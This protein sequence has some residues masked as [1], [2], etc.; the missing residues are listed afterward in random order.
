MA[1]TR[2]A[3]HQLS[4][5]S[6]GAF[7]AHCIPIIAEDIRE[8]L[9]C[10]VASEFCCS[11]RNMAMFQ[12]QPL[13]PV[14]A[15]TRLLILHGGSPGSEIHCSVHPVS[16]ESI[17]SYE[18]LSYVW[19][20]ASAS[21]VVI[22]AGAS[23]QVT[24]SLHAALCCLR[25]PDRDCTLWVDAL[26]INQDDDNERTQ[27]VSKMRR[28]YE[29]AS[30]VISWLG[31][32][33]EGSD[34]AMRL[35]RYIGE[36]TRRQGGTLLGSS[37][38]PSRFTSVSDVFEHYGLQVRAQNW[39]ALWD[40]LERPYWSRIWIVQELSVR[41][42]L[43]RSTGVLLCGGA[44][45]ERAMYDFACAWLESVLPVVAQRLVETG[46][47]ADFGEPYSTLTDR[48]IPAG[49]TMSQ[50]IAACNAKPG[51]DLESLIAAT[52]RFEASDPRDKIFALAGI[53]AKVDLGLEVNYTKSLRDVL[54][55]FVKY[56]LEKRG[57]L[58]VLVGNRQRI[59]PTDLAPSW[60]PDVLV[61]TTTASNPFQAPDGEQ[62]AFRAS[63][64]RPPVAVFQQGTDQLQVEGIKLGVLKKVIG[65]LV[66]GGEMSVPKTP[67]ITISQA[68]GG[69]ELVEKLKEYRPPPDVDHEAFWRTL[70][71]DRYMKEWEF[72]HPAPVEFGAMCRVLLGQGSVPAD[73]MPGARLSARKMSYRAPFMQAMLNSVSGRSFFDTESGLMGLGPLCCQPGDVVA[74]V[75]GCRS[76]LVLRPVG[77]E[78]QLVGDAYVHGVMEGQL[79][80]RDL[81]SEMLC[82]V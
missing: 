54:K 35:V 41:G 78:F 37:W 32:E 16:L 25:H 81:T 18:A 15:D 26:C 31:E 4:I 38:D 19:G 45:V 24:D 23:H 59:L 65:P 36:W 14:S 76:C 68:I 22:L 50:T 44:A 27:Q 7:V 20:S 56:S 80:S 51:R 48:G 62:L 3:T 30:T 5:P 57:N 47:D 58:N 42:R 66:L 6:L 73:F 28:I 39:A 69:D 53:A 60:A 34:E 72:L 10:I 9:E 61:P 79:M 74:L 77:Y 12:Y 70:V 63:G 43:S 67:G 52:A 21:K 1:A 46:I 40:L 75:L 64:T 82:L 8:Q 71:M 29:Q 17:P 13:G 2:S 33:S 11:N 55:D 49:M